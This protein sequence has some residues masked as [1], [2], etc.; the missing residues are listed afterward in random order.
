MAPPIPDRWIPYKACGKVIE[1]TRI[2]CFKVPLRKAVQIGKSE[3]KEIWDIKALLENIPNLGAVIDLTN[4]ARYYDPRELQAAGVLHQKIL[5]PGRIIPPENKVQRFMDTV[6]EFLGKDCVAVQVKRARLGLST[7]EF[8]VGVHCTHGLNRTGY[9]V[10]RYMRDRLNIPGQL[11]IKRFEKARGYQIER[12]NYVA[13]I[14]GEKPPPPDLNF[15][16]GTNIK[17]LEDG[18]KDNED[19][20]NRHEKDDR[21]TNDKTR[22]R[23]KDI[24][25][26]NWRSEENR[27]NWRSE[28]QTGSSSSRN[29]RSQEDSRGS[30]R[31]E[32]SGSW[33]R[34][35]TDSESSY[36]FKYDY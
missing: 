32:T 22:R 31:A 5:M 8:L 16:K 35:K 24:D 30:R 25:N 9:M 23:K 29:W 18:D 19:E 20:D 34:K 15:R 28:A 12:E 26:R 36:N 2:I 33:R 14:L 17:S 10:C 11:A 6:D 4:T 27:G 7:T 21:N 1:G 3:I 13:D